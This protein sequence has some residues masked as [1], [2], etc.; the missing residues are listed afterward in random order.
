MRIKGKQKTRQVWVDGLELTPEISQAVYNHSPDGFSWGYEGSGPAQLAL[1]IML[2]ITLDDE[3]AIR[4][5][6]H[7]KREIIAKLPQNDFDIEIDVIGWGL[8][9]IEELN[10]NGDM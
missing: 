1:S 6:Q 10:K 8:N 7:F 5:Y 9:K 2:I 4:L 3:S